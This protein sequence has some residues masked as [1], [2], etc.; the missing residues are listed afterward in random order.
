MLSRYGVWLLVA[1]TKPFAG[2]AKHIVG[3]LIGALFHWFD[4]TAYVTDGTVNHV[5]KS[6]KDL[7][8]LFFFS[9]QAVG[10]LEPLKSELLHDWIVQ[11]QQNQLDVFIDCL[12]PWPASYSR[13]G[14]SWDTH[15]SRAVHIKEG[16][17]RLFCLVPYEIITVDLWNHVIPHWLEAIVTSV[18]SEEWSE[19]RITLR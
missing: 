3:R 19:F 15:S 2:A 18:P 4:T 7:S 12:L 6:V 10:V 11:G 9:D 5:K 13:V 14:G 8:L 1:L 17:N 16:F